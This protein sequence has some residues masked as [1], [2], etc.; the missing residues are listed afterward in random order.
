MS[1]LASQICP[2]LRAFFHGKTALYLAIFS[3]F[4]MCI[5]PAQAKR[6]EL[7]QLNILADPAISIPLSVIARHYGRSHAV[8]LNLSFASTADQT[9]R[10]TQ[11]MEA[12]LFITT[13]E[14]T[15][16][17][18]QNQGVVDVYS[19]VAIAKG[20]L[21]LATRADNPI[22]LTLIQ[23]LPLRNLLAGRDPEFSLIMHD[24]EY[25]AAGSFAMEALRSYGLDGEME[26]HFLFLQSM[27]D[28]QKVLEQRGMYGIVLHSE[29]ISNPLL[30][31][32]D[33]FPENAH[34]PLLYRGVVVAS[35]Q[36][37]AS[38]SFLDYLR[39]PPAQA[40]FRSYGFF[41]VE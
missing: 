1:S 21:V 14:K 6:V 32:I 13:R 18:L 8:V 20:R 5:A 24:P 16:K 33:T 26:P 31:I 34:S 2:A 4:L 35:E 12:D 39:T 28:V 19:E 9:S 23:G 17:F 41:A 29:V 27:M 37:D 15:I 7:P 38:R 22:S 25:L 36:M 11:G 10:I 30:R 40:I 3:L